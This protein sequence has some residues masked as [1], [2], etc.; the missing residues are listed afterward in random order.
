[1]YEWYKKAR[2]CYAYLA[3]VP[4]AAVVVNPWED[5]RIDEAEYFRRSH[6]FTRGWTLQELIAP[7]IVEFY[8]ADCKS[9]GPQQ[10]VI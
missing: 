1:M 7:D 3:D 8:A 10:S 9:I 5:R 2:V 6:W 4:N